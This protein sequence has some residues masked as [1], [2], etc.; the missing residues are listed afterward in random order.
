MLSDKP[1]EHEKPS[2]S[3]TTID[4]SQEW[5]SDGMATEDTRNQGLQTDEGED[6]DKPVEDVRDRVSNP[7]VCGVF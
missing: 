7:V 4:R 5:K 1:K 6:N 2:P 3:P